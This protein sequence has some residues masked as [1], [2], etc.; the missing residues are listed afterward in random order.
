VQADEKLAVHYLSMKIA[1]YLEKYPQDKTLGSIGDV[2]GNV[3]STFIKRADLRD[4]YNRFHS[5]NTKFAQLFA[6]ELALPTPAPVATI[7]KDESSGSYNYDPDPVFS[8]NLKSAL[9]N[10]PLKPYSEKAS[11]DAQRFAANTLERWNIKPSKLKVLDGNDKFIIMA[12]SYDTPKGET[13]VL[14][15][16]E[17]D[18]EKAVAPEI[19]V[20]NAGVED[21]NNKTIKSY[22]ISNAGSKLRITG[23]SLL[24]V[25]ASIHYLIN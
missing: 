14:I 5:S 7:Q 24:G 15:P 17:I 19:F 16:V 4:L 18:G 23:K 20:S 12:A 21:L 13:S 11:N 1:K 3:N 6:D 2:L 10:T 22:I 25:L 8:E 9:D